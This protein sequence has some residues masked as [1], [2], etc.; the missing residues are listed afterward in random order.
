MAITLISDTIRKN[1][2]AG[3]LTGAVFLDVQKAF[4]TVSNPKLLS[5]L[6]FF[7]IRDNELNWFEDYLLDRHI[8]VGVNG[9][10]CSS[11]P[12]NS[13]VPQGSILGALLFI[14]HMNDLLLTPFN[15]NLTHSLTHSA[16]HSPPPAPHSQKYATYKS[17]SN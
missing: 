13:G 3:L 14:M 10:L 7:G 1:S 17:M 15:S 11:F 8:Q 12:V 5:K 16:P 4:D 9:A 2:E 6:R